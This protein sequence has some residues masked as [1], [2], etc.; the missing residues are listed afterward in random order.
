MKFSTLITFYTLILGSS[1]WY[2]C[3]QNRDKFNR[4]ILP[5]RRGDEGNCVGNGDDA[6]HSFG[7]DPAFPCFKDANGCDPD[8]PGGAY[9]GHH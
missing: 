9:C 6:G 2:N 5:G 3:V 7:C 1:A 8:A 4:P